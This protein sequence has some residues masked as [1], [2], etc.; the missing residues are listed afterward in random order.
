MI[1]PV[2]DPT[3]PFL[4]VHITKHIDSSVSLGPTAMMV[5]SRDGYVAEVQCARCVADRYLAGN[6]ALG[7]A[8]LAYGHP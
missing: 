2:P 7:A 1:Y 8:V 3:L 6:V 5:P 4:G